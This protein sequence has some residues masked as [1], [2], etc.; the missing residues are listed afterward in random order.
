MKG[1]YS[2]TIT[3]DVK[4][5]YRKIRHID[6]FKICLLT[7]TKN[8]NTILDKIYFKINRVFSWIKNIAIKKK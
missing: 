2:K 7:K 3:H 1:G 8:R 6:S 4:D 5:I